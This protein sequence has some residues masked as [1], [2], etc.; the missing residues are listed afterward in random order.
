MSLMLFKIII[1]AFQ[2]I[3]ESQKNIVETKKYE[4]E[5]D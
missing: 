3:T 1:F 2:K 4:Y 5:T